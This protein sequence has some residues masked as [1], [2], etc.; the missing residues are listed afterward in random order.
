VALY[1]NIKKIRDV[2]LKIQLF[3][4]GT[5]LLF[6]AFITQAENESK[7]VPTPD[8]S[9]IHL[10]DLNIEDSRYLLKNGKNISNN[11]DYDNQ[12]FFADNSDA[13]LFVSNR[14]GKQTDIYEYQINSAKT[15]QLTHTAHSEFSPKYF[16]EG[17]SITYVSE[18]GIPYQSV[19]K[20]DRKSGNS[21]WLLN[22]KEPV[23]Y[24]AVN[25]KTGDV[26]FWSRYGWSVQFLNIKRDEERFVSGN[27]IP[28]SPQQIP[29]SELFSFVH[30]QSN[31]EVWIKSF[32][33]KTFSI[34][35]LAPIYGSN[36]DYTWAPNGDIVRVEKNQLFIFPHHGQ[37][38]RTGQDLSEHFSGQIS[39]LA[40]SANSKKI[41]LVENR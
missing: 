31:G 39:R 13:V 26:L 9:E 10:F 5:F 38:W 6:I 4:L 32:D 7:P 11:L 1:N 2:N 40:I 22:S 15:I 41:A 34:T 20:L 16:N 3:I 18:G 27:A 35:P 29:N 17:A 12:P 25:D 37:S 14:D 24:Y 19:W 33:P 8:N 23:G 30:R 21:T 28:S 36:Y